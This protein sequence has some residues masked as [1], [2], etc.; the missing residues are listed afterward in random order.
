MSTINVSRAMG[1]ALVFFT[2]GF[3]GLVYESIWTQYIKLFLGHAAYAQIFVLCLF[4]GG[5]AFGAFVVGRFAGRWMR[6]MGCYA[7]IELLIG[8]MGLFFHQQYLWGMEVFY[9]YL[10]PLM[11]QGWLI[12]GAKWLAA[13]ILILPQTILL[14][15]TFPI[16]AGAVIRKHQDSSGRVISLLYFANSLGGAIG[17]LVSGFV[18]IEQVGLPGTILTA[19]LL[20]CLVALSAWR[21]SKYYDQQPINVDIPAAAVSTV[22][23]PIVAGVVLSGWAILAIAALTGAAS[24]MYEVGWIRMLSLVMGS[25]TH[26][27]ELMLSA[28]I[29]GLALGSFWIR[30]RL[31]SFGDPIRVL[32]YIQLAMAFAAA[33]TIPLYNHVFSW[34]AWMMGALERSEAGYGLY[35]LFSHVL[36]LCVM[37]PATVLAG[38]TLPLLTK[39]LLRSQSGTQSVGYVYAANTVGAIMGI[40]VGGFWIMPTL[41][42][43]NVVAA[44]AIVDAMVGIMLIGVIWYSISKYTRYGVV[45]SGIAIILLCSQF[46]FDVGLMGSGVYRTGSLMSAD[47]VVFHR[48]GVTATI[49]VEDHKDHKAIRTNGKPDAAMSFDSSPT[50]D[51]TTMILLGALPLSVHPD[52]KN[53][54]VIGLGSGLTSHA[55]LSDSRLAHVTTIE[56][57]PAMIEGA[58]LFGDRVKRV[59]E[60]ER[61]SIVVED[62]KTYFVKQK[63]KYDFIVSEP[64]NPW[65]SGVA[66]LFTHEFYRLA[67]SHLHPQGVFVQWIHLYEID[68][69][70]LAPVFKALGSVFE[71][72]TL[73]VTHDYDAIVVASAAGRVPDP[74]GAIFQQPELAVLLQRV[75][76]KSLTDLAIRRI[77]S[78]AH[79]A[80][81]FEA[82]PLPEN[83]DYFPVLDAHA[84]AARFRGATATMLPE[85]FGV[86]AALES[87]H[88]VVWDTVTPDSI[89][90]GA[91]YSAGRAQRFFRA[92]ASNVRS[93]QAGEDSVTDAVK[94]AAVRGLSDCAPASAD[95]AMRVVHYILEDT[96]RFLTVAQLQSLVARFLEGSCVINAG[97]AGRA[98]L[99]L[100]LARARGDYAKVLQ[101]A[102]SVASIGKIPPDVA[103][104]MLVESAMVASLAQGDANLATTWFSRLADPSKA[105]PPLRYLA[106]LALQRS[107]RAA[108]QAR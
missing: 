99:E 60:D 72:Y 100:Y 80:P 47:A 57:E 30:T 3:S 66:S 108:S 19:G 84:S 37:L 1:L 45:A 79:L 68:V 62:A 12:D 35:L 65:V 42:L 15:M 101:H 21:L 106:V 43:K 61:G 22:D 5:M 8:F 69:E 31:D 53:V 34:M 96:W 104:Q 82:F 64:S 33:C 98:W 95:Q 6:L 63:E 16:F 48:D 13:M 103:G 10:L 18:L 44:G 14:G 52:P 102:N 81:Y 97:D 29:L 24:F 58:R 75:G 74:S 7:L 92:L 17:V 73:Y 54:A 105:K 89:G 85:Y 88:E 41:G 4:M 78:K 49:T 2:S 20:N 70:T 27:F 11:G 9:Q 86:I 93:A 23:K 32:A 91:S 76:I 50:I 40:L 26:S 90:F 55:L 67:K 39:I 83:S 71:D 46:S 107:H 36:A 59:F 87:R 94:L 51:E 38:M 56:I 25:A 77:G 28:F